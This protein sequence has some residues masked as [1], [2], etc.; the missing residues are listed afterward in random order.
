MLDNVYILIFYLFIENATLT[1][2]I[3]GTPRNLNQI[4][5]DSGSGW[6][7]SVTSERQASVTLDGGESRND[8]N[9]LEL[10]G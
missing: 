7:V 10:G 8:R 2:F 1:L 4:N 6:S 9:S 5:S 3:N